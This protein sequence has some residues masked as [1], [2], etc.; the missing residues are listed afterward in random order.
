V[1]LPDPRGGCTR[2]HHDTADIN[3]GAPHSQ[4]TARADADGGKMD[5]FIK[6]VCRYPGNPDCPTGS[7]SGVM[8]YHNAA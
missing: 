8:G 3:A 7:P 1:C 4:I 5:G 6:A 2:P